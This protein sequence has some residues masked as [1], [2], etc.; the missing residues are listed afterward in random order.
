MQ[1][2][3][4]PVVPEQHETR[5]RIER[6]VLYLIAL[7]EILIWLFIVGITW[8]PYLAASII[9]FMT[10]NIIASLTQGTRREFDELLPIFRFWFQGL[11]GVMPIRLAQHTLDVVPR[12]R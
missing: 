12:L 11:T 3:N 1:E 4:E 6:Y 2:Y 8:P 5:A 7:L 9:I 10:E